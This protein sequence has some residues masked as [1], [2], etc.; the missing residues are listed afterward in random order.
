MDGD[1]SMQG[2]VVRVFY[3]AIIECRH[4]A[5]CRVQSSPRR[6]TKSLVER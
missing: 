5:C 2:S 6:D 4:M 1:V 3:P